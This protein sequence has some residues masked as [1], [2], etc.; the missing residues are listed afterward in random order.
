MNIIIALVVAVL[1]YL[2]VKTVLALVKPVAH[3][4]EA[5]GIIAGALVALV[6]MGII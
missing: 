2:I 3:L 5:I 1:V 4:A 6:M